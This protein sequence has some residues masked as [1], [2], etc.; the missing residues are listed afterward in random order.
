M[1][2]PKMDS[3]TV[4]NAT[5]SSDE[6]G[7]TV[8][9]TRDIN[10]KRIFSNPILYAQ[11]LRD[12]FDIPILKNVQPE[13]IEDVSDRYQTY[14]GIEFESDTVKKIRL[15]DREGNLRGESLYLI[16]LLDHKS[17]VDYNV[18][19][20][21]LRYMVCI[22]DD[23]GKEEE[24]KK[25]KCTTRKGF[26]Y[27]AILPIVYYEG[28]RKWTAGLHL[29]DRIQ[30]SDVFGEY[31]PD[32]T[33]EVIRNHDY[34]N[35]ELLSRGDEMS[36]IMLINKIQ[37]AEDFHQFRQMS[38]EEMDQILDEAPESIIKV[39]ADTLYS[40]LMK[41]NVPVDEANEYVDF[42]EDHHMGYLFENMEKMDIQEER[43]HTAEA[44]KQLAK[45]EEKLSKSEEKL[46]KSEEKL[47][48]TVEKLENAEKKLSDK[49]NE[50][51]SL[52][53]KIRLLESGA[54]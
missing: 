43:R 38:A 7:R 33:Y 18:S 2:K 23:Y 37:S 10:S 32:F 49:D 51:A 40:L 48:E 42:V 8:A 20:Q 52:Q 9:K 46:S 1:K 29:R 44:R 30:M 22:W 6:A 35:E 19:M 11:F 24:Q 25:A 14:L 28:K 21:L 13:D 47:S 3:E 31:T 54:N 15:R 17:Y 50:I 53:N 34:S 16:S 27:P 41:M 45:S 26:R 12:N 39:I 4:V 5:L 36:L